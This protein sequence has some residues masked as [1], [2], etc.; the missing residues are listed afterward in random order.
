MA[1]ED[2]AFCA[3]KKCRDRDWYRNPMHISHFIPH[4]FALFTG[5]KKWNDK[6]AEWLTKQM[7]REE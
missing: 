5:C 2:I 7:D 1:S 3:N 6:G 4:S